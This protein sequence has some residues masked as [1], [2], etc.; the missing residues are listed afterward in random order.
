MDQRSRKPTRLK[1][2]DYSAPGAYFITICTRDRQCILSEIGKPDGGDV[3]EQL[4]APVAEL[5][6]IGRLVEEQIELLPERFP[7]LS[8]MRYV[9]MP[10]HIHLLLSQ[11]IEGVVREQQA[12]PLQGKPEGTVSITRAVQALK[13][14]T[15]RLS[16][17]GSLW[18]RSFYDHVIRNEDDLRQIAEYIDTNPARWESDRFRAES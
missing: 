7:A 1:N 14:Q 16:G 5:T 10:N 18:Q 8:V 6:A 17:V 3:G 2:Y 4:A 13:S 12:A 15:S 11:G 9:I